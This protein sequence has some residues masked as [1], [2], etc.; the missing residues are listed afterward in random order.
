MLSLTDLPRVFLHED[1]PIL[2]GNCL[3]HELNLSAVNPMC[4]S[5]LC[6]WTYY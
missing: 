3:I 6:L 4:W 1:M 5:V 2:V